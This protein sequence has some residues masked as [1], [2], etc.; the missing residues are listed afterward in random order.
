MATERNTPFTFGETAIRLQ[1]G[2]SPT[3]FYGHLR[4]ISASERMSFVRLCVQERNPQGF[5]K[6]PFLWESVREWISRRHHLTP[7][8]IG[9]AGSAQLGFSTNP[10]KQWAQFNPQESDLD[11]FI[12]DG[13]LFEKVATEAR[14]FV[15]NAAVRNT[16]SDQ[17]STTQTTLRRGYVNLN[18]IPADH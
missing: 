8:Q 2:L 16:L 17:A 4:N 13:H 6:Q 15:A 7:R 9:L 12:V 3:E 14:L 18:Q 11:L 10:N 1:D 5:S